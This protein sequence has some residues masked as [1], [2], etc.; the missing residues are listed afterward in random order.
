MDTLPQSV[1]NQS[2]SSVPPVA[3]SNAV[4][5][6]VKELEISRGPVIEASDRSDGFAETPLSA[7]VAHAGVRMKTDTI[8]LPK[9]VSQL[10]VT[11]VSQAPSAPVSAVPTIVL[12][13]TDEQIAQGLQQSITSSFRWLAEW[14]E[15]RLKEIHFAVR[16]IGG[17]VA[18]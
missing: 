5:S 9:P 12:P 15:R 11:V 10:G 3:P 17:S 7:E 8:E 1:S 4:G 16:S 2:S 13:L 6:V 18:R 14:C